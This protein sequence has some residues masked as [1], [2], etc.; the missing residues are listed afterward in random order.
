[1]NNTLTSTDMNL[2]RRHIKLKQPLI[3]HTPTEDIA[4]AL[5]EFL[6]NLGLDIEGVT[7]IYNIYKG[8]TAYCIHTSGDIGYAELR[9]FES[10]E[11]FRT[12]QILKLPIL[13]D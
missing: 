7:D 12:Q 8:S 9:F 6:A 2:I 3:M 11:D 10:D 4:N 1:M 5:H 13:K